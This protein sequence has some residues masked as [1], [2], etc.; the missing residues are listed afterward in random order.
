MK[1]FTTKGKIYIGTKLPNWHLEV[2]RIRTELFYNIGL[3]HIFSKNELKLILG[4]I[5]IKTFYK[6][7]VSK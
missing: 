1:S 6:D 5:K 2:I 3:K 4:H 7:N